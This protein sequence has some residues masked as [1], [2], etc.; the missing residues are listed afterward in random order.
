[1]F[2]GHEQI[3]HPGYSVVEKAYIGIFGMPIVGLRIRARNVFSLIPKKRSYRN[4]LDAGSGPGVFSFEL[5]RRFPEA[6]VIG[7]DLL[8]ESIQACERISKKLKITNVQFQQSPIE[9]LRQH[10]FFSLILCIDILEHI[11]DDLAALK[12]LYHAAEPGGAVL[13]APGVREDPAGQGYCL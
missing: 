13:R 7:V 6:M 9:D 12:G 3:H 8:K 11:R 2:I 4:I 1:M 5:G 10:N